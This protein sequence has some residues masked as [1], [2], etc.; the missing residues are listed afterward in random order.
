MCERRLYHVPSAFQCVYGC[1]NE[2]S[3]GR[4]GMRFPEE[5]SVWRLLGLMYADDLLLCGEME[6]ELKVM[7]G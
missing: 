3:E 1:S 4:I 2:R 7:V 6:E 5:G